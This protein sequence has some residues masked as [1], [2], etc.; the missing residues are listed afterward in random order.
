MRQLEGI[1]VKQVRRFV[2]AS[3]LSL[4]ALLS[5]VC[6]GVAPGGVSRAGLK[7][8]RAD[9]PT[10]SRA[11]R[12]EPADR[13]SSD[14]LEVAR[15][16]AA[17]GRRIRVIL[18]EGDGAGAALAALLR[19]REVKTRGRFDTLGTRVLE[20]PAQLVERLSEQKGVR[21]VSLDRETISFG[22]VSRTTGTDDVRT[23]VG[24]NVSGLDGAGIAIAVL[25]SGID[26]DHLAFRDGGN[27]LRVVK[28][29]DFTGEG[30]TDDPYGHGTHV[31][32]IAAGN[33]RI[34]HAEYIGI[35]PAAKLINLRVLNSQGTGR[36][37]SI[38]CA[39]DWVLQN[40]AAYNIRV[41]NMSLGTWA[42]ESYKNDPLCKAVRKL[43]DA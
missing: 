11:R 18:Q 3:F 14:L 23:T 20:L 16:P 37:S 42:V 26:T 7:L 41:V 43:V 35:A 33:G 13:I 5:L 29:L 39:L 21:F 4:L 17:R 8:M 9:A 27:G 34:A 15:D 6:T 19:G 36:T 12:E 2:A 10:S 24:T 25:D 38:L 32:S 1:K 40:R 31:A 22:H 30:R 28:S